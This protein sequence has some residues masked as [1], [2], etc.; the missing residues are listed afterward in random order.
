MGSSPA[1]S[2]ADIQP[3]GPPTATCTCPCGVPS[4]DAEKLLKP[5]L[6]SAVPAST[7]D[8]E[9]APPA[10]TVARRCDAYSGLVASAGV[11]N[12]AGRTR[13]LVLPGAY[14]QYGSEKFGSPDAARTIRSKWCRYMRCH[15]RKNVLLCSHRSASMPATGALAPWMLACAAQLVGSDAGRARIVCTAFL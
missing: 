14:P 15:D 2:N 10:L 9:I 11:R 6:A 5:T 7:A 3:P 8:A 12:G 4:T 13:V 1:V